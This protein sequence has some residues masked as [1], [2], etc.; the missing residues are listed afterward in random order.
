LY[1][2]PTWTLVVAYGVKDTWGYLT[3]SLGLVDHKFYRELKNNG[4]L[5]K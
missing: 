2:S 1:Y 4:Q 5:P 3:D